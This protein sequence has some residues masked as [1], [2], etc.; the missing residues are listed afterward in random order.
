VLISIKIN[1][2]FAVYEVFTIY[3]TSERNSVII[4]VEPLINFANKSESSFTCLI[5]FRPFAK[6]EILVVVW[7]VVVWGRTKLTP[8]FHKRYIPKNGAIRYY[9]FI[10]DPK[11]SS[12]ARLFL[13][14][15]TNVIA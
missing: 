13:P 11:I 5:E 10:S 8:R 15:H 2:L 4:N 9:E 14:Q 3:F 12:I 6:L 7:L 1:N